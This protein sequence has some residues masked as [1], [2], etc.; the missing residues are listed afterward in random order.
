MRLLPLSV[1]ANIAAIREASG[2]RRAVRIGVSD[3]VSVPVT[4]GF[5]DPYVLIPAAHAEVLDVHSLTQIIAHELAHVARHDDWAGLAQRLLSALFFFQPAVHYM[6]RRLDLER[7]LACDDLVMYRTGSSSESYA[8]CLLRVGELA[9]GGRPPPAG[10]LSM[11]SQLRR[12]IEVLL[13]TRPR[14]SQKVFALVA[15]LP[16]LVMLVLAATPGLRFD[17]LPA[18]VAAPGVPVVHGTV[19]GNADAL[20]RRF[21]EYGFHGA[22]LIAHRGAVVLHEGYGLADRERGTPFTPGTAFN[23]GAVAKM[24]TAAAILKLEEQGRLRTTD[25]VADYLGA[26]PAPKSDVTIHQLLTHTGGITRLWAP[27][28]RADRAEFVQVMKETPADYPAGAGHRYTDHGHALLAAVIEVASGMSYEDYVHSA[29][30]E[31]AGLTNTRFEAESPTSAPLAVEYADYAG[32]ASRVGMR[33]YVWGRRG[34]MGV[35]T[36]VEDLWR[37]HRAIEGGRILGQDARTRMLTGWTATGRPTRIGYGW[38]VGTSQ[39]GTR[40]RHRLSAWSTNSVEV[41][42]D[43]DEDL[44]IA[45]T[46]N[47]P[48]NWARPKYLEVINAAL[49][50]EHLDPPAPLPVTRAALLPFEGRYQLP[51]GGQIDVAADDNGGLMLHTTGADATLAVT[52]QDFPRTTVL[53]RA[54]SERSVAVLQWTRHRI[55][56]VRFDADT[57]LVHGKP[58]AMRIRN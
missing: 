35:I 28:Q 29:L 6:A 45:F 10:A 21:E 25:R 12:R 8:R 40:I 23:G 31:P 50:L 55:A 15:P 30:L 48:T 58:V 49:G 38:E 47:S 24:L 27:V 7:E 2:V 51:S 17:T 26:F 3:D 53:A 5:L 33:P 57:L 44:F 11:A 52:G 19:A 20:F 43:E 13:D 14:A 1:R 9:V 54:T 4:L 16:V 18:A 56:S 39:R 36:T 37:W 32:S 42:Y 34:A 46:A 22:V 41:V